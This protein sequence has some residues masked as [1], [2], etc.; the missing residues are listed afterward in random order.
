V[1]P[2]QTKHFSVGI[3]VPNR[4]TSDL[5]HSTPELSGLVSL[6]LNGTPVV[7]AIQKGYALITRDWKAGDRIEFTLPMQPQRIKSDDKVQ[8]NRGQVALRYGP[9]IYSVERADQPGLSLSLSKTPVTAEWRPELLQG[10]V[11]L[12]GTWADGSPMLAIPYYAR[13]NRTNQVAVTRGAGGDGNRS[14]SSMV[15]IKDQ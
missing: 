11:A 4:Q 9:V 3:R 7:P 2:K 10:V 15:W 1:N 13:Q 8:A 6:S 14:A 12:K 5:Y